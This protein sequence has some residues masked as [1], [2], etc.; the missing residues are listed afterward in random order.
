MLLIHCILNNSLL[1]FRLV[2]TRT[3]ETSYNLLVFLHFL[4]IV[5]ELH[6]ADL[7]AFEVFCT[8]T[9]SQK[10]KVDLLSRFE[11]KKRLKEI[12]IKEHKKSFPKP[13]SS[14]RTFKSLNHQT[15]NLHGGGLMF[16]SSGFLNLIV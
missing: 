14:H 11:F 15:L 9:D 4:F 10:T 1:P 8:P 16:G 2:F 3:T 13:P 7:R 5:C 12:I 6:R